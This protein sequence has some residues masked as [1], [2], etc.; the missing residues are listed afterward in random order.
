MAS[1]AGRDEVRSF[2]ARVRA[3]FQRGEDLREL[4]ERVAALIRAQEARSEQLIGWV[5]LAIVA[6][7][8]TLYL[9]APRPVDLR[10]GIEPVPVALAAY[11]VLTIARLALSYRRPLPAWLLL[12]SIVLDMALMLGLIWW[13]HI[14]YGQPAPFTLK[15]PM[16][17]YMFIFIALRALRF[18][19]R[20]V[21]A[22]GLCAAL[23]WGLLTLWVVAGSPPSA[24]TRNFTVYLTSNMVLVGAEVEKIFA[25]TMVTL[26]LTLAVQRARR[27]LVTAVR[28]QAAGKDLRRFLSDDVADAI[29]T[30]DQELQAGTAAAREAAI[31]MLDL[32]GFT[33]ATARL[34]PDEIV[35]LLTGFH[36][37]VVPI[38]EA[39][40]GLI[41]KFLGD[42]VMATFGAVRPQPAAAERALAALEAIVAA[43]AKWEREAAA[44]AKGVRLEVNAAVTAGEVMFVV[45]GSGER[46]EYTVIGE[47]VNLA[48]KLEKHNKIEGTRAIV[49]AAAFERARAQGYVPR[50]ALSLHRSAQVSG[51]GGGIDI[52]ALAK[53][54]G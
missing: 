27:T 42:G 25:L 30:S 16:F 11:G 31:M 21:L 24:I 36:A 46:L 53:T 44:R 10:M 9:L 3:L 7:F 38:I 33:A 35:G 50:L 28:E 22:A 47:V 49:S 19:H 14:Q 23:G 54:G 29:A 39:H 2:P 20:Y 52:F 4:P 26:L 6:L 1:V 41:D 51:V 34:G 5:Q 18:D 40:G 17:V 37:V 8:G 45:I 13:F 15:I 43:S 48:A 12:L 32:R